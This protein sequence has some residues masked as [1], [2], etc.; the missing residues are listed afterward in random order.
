MSQTV[1]CTEE[2][3][4]HRRCNCQKHCTEKI[5]MSMWKGRVSESSC[6]FAVHLEMSLNVARTPL[7]Q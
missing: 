3:E 1:S 2:A 4:Q 5:K 7:L 6:K